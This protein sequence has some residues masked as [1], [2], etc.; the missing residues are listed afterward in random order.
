[1][2]T[3]LGPASRSTVTYSLTMRLAA[4]TYRLPGPAIIRHRGTVSVPYAI[5][6]M[7]CAPPTLNTRYPPTRPAA[8]SVTGFTD[9]SA[10]GGTQKT[11]SS[12]P[13]TLAGIP[14]I[15]TVDG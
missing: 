8:A 6:A 7:A 5:A 15:K 14:V 4:A 3:S 10:P 13:A 12:T 1:M 11:I 2:T 9:P